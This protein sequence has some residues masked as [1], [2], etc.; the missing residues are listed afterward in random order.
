V[1]LTYTAFYARFVCTRY[2]FEKGI[3]PLRSSTRTTLAALPDRCAAAVGRLT[4]LAYT[5]THEEMRAQ[6]TQVTA[7][8]YAI[9]EQRLRTVTKEEDLPGRRISWSVFSVSMMWA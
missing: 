7:N 3:T 2:P 1:I 5:L 9:D 4:G 6:V 8:S